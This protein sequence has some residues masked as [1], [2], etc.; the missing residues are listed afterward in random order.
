[1]YNPATNGKLNICEQG[2]SLLHLEN[3]FPRLFSLTFVFPQFKC[4]FN[5]Y[6]MTLS[7]Y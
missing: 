6:I 7:M 3:T 2:F 5:E 1:M 4:L